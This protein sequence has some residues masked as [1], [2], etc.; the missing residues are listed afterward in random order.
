MRVRELGRL[1]VITDEE[2]QGRFSHLE[3]A[4]LAL[5]GGATVVQYRDKRRLSQAQRTGVARAIV[6]AARAWGARVIV[7]DHPEVARRAGAH[8]VHLGPADV[9]PPTARTALGRWPGI[10]GGTAN[11]YDEALRVAQ[12]GVDYL[13]VGPVYGTR[14]KA[15]PAP[16]LGLR[17]LQRI[18]AAVDCPV[19]AI[20]GMRPE[21]VREV[22][23]AGAHGVAVLSA[24]AA[25]ADPEQATRDFAA[26]LSAGNQE[27]RVG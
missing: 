17:M 25:A 7:N 26:A 15:L 5:R 24:V 13:G 8:G 16:R 18:C 14:S 6:D 21:R 9:T 20:G 22:L 2:L 11:G 12:S 19:V 23:E 3:L 10:I 1:H 27:A 4:G